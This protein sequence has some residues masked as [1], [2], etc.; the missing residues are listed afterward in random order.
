MREDMNFLSM[1]AD[2]L[3]PKTRGPQKQSE[4][5][6]VNGLSWSEGRMWRFKMA[7]KKLYVTVAVMDGAPPDPPNADD[8]F[9]RCPKKK[10]TN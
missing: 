10:S 9:A 1:I 4:L 5:H 2:Q 7:S 6:G 8:R 3:W